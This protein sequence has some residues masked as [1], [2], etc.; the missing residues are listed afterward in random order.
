VTDKEVQARAKMAGFIDSVIDT[1]ESTP[2]NEDAAKGGKKATS[3][4]ER[5]ATR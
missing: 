1:I 3:R 4:A 2:P 5:P